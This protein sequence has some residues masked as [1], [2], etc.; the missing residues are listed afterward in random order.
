MRDAARRER[1]G[2][3]TMGPLRHF[4]APKKTLGDLDAQAAAA[5]VAAASDVALVID[6]G[7]V[8]RDVA[9]ADDEFALDGFEGWIGKPWVETVTV[10]SRGKVQSLLRDAAAEAPPR[11]RQI[12]AVSIRGGDVPLLFSALQVGARPRHVT[13]CCSRWRSRQC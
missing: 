2:V 3:N 5:L 4:K 1:A 7:G 9:L 12:N 11:W 8:V 10:E 13:G 6:A